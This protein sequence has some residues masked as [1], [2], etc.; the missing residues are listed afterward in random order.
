MAKFI[1]IGTHDFYGPSTREIEIDHLTIDRHGV[2]RVRHIF[3]SRED[4]EAYIEKLDEA[5]YDMMH[6]ESGRPSYRVEEADYEC[7]A[8]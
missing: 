6:N 1:I 7:A 4:A 3:N 8:E 2:G 5:R